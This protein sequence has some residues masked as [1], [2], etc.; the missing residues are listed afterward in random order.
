[1]IAQHCAVAQKPSEI[2]TQGRRSQA[3]RI[4]KITAREWP[5][6]GLAEGLAKGLAKQ[7][8]RGLAKAKGLAEGLAKGLAEGLAKG[9]AWGLAKMNT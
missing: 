9:P 5:A 6:K 3:T 2:L 7:L 4:Q 8:A 1:M